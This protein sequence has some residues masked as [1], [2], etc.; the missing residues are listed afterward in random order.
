MMRC[1]ECRIEDPSWSH[2]AW[3]YRR[4]RLIEMGRDEDLEREARRHAREE[5]RREEQ[6]H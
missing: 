6:A 5:R 4:R 1:G 3:H 2:I